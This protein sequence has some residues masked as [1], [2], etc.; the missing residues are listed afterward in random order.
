MIDDFKVFLSD[1]KGTGFCP[2]G[3]RAFCE[4]HGI[5]WR[6]YCKNGVMASKLIEADDSMAA[7]LVEKAR[8]NRKQGK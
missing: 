1:S 8:E 7:R 6:D 5:D 2:S 4:A 3:Q